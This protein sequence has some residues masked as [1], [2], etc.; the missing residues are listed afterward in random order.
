MGKNSKKY[1]AISFDYDLTIADTAKIIA[2]RL[3]LTLKTYG[4]P[5]RTFEEISPYIGAFGYE[6]IRSLTC[7]QNEERLMEMFQFYR[8]ECRQII[9]DTSRLFVGVAEGAKILSG[10]GMRLAIVSLKPH[11]QIT[12]P[13]RQYGVRSCFEIVIG[14]D[15]LSTRKPDPA[16][17]EYV[18]QKFGVEKDEFL[19]VGDSLTDQQTAQNAGVDF[20]AML[21]GFTTRQQFEVKGADFYFSNMEDLCEKLI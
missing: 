3:N 18:L 21:T 8:G 17:I 16:G 9:P 10:A 11:S 5:Q 19:Y 4:Y 12:N 14:G 15:D 1:K 7:E 20:G 13:L 2:Q 6:I